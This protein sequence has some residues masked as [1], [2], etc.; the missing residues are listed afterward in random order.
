MTSVTF[1]IDWE[2]TAEREKPWVA[3]LNVPVALPSEL[4]EPSATSSL[5]ALVLHAGR[6]P[7][8]V[9]ELTV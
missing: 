1:S 8:I 7:V 6:I 4:P 9:P 2:S 5:N 3:P